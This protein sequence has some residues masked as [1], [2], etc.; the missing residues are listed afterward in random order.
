M[1][2]VP[3]GAA[4]S[5]DTVPSRATRQ[6]YA[7]GSDRWVSELRP[8]FAEDGASFIVRLEDTG[9]H[10]TELVEVAADGSRVRHGT[11]A[12]T[13]SELLHWDRRQ[14]WM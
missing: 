1:T 13:V 7:A 6:E 10:G 9:A 5:P 14:H 2:C 3:S 4:V 12:H 11:Q 8:V